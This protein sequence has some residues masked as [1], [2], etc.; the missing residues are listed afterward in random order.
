MLSGGSLSLTGL[1]VRNG[2]ASSGSNEQHGG[3]IRNAATLSIDSSVITGNT[4]QNASG[5]GVYST[6]TLIVTSSTISNNRTTGAGANGAGIFSGQAASSLS[7]AD[8]TIAH[9]TADGD[10]G[11][12]T[13]EQGWASIVRSAVTENTTRFTGLGGGIVALTGTLVVVDSNIS[14]N[15][16]ATIG[17]GIFAGGTFSLTRSSI[18]NN[19]A[20]TDGGGVRTG[21]TGGDAEITSSTISGNRSVGFG[22]G[23]EHAASSRNDILR[24]TNSTISD[25]RVWRDNQPAYG[26]GG[27]IALFGESTTI[28]TLRLFHVTLAGNDGQGGGSAIYAV[29]GR[30][31]V[32]NSILDGGAACQANGSVF[33]SLGNN[34]ERGNT[35]GFGAPSDRTNVDPLLGALANNGGATNTN[36]PLAGSP[37]IDGVVGVCA[38]ATDQ[39]GQPRPRDGDGNGTAICDIGA[40]ELQ[41]PYPSISSF[42]INAGQMATNA[43]TVTL[44]LAASASAAEMRFS[45]DGTNWPVGWV[46]F[47][48]SAPWTVPSG[49]GTKTVYA[50]V[51]DSSGNASAI[52]TDTIVLDTTANAGSLSVNADAPATNTLNVTLSL[53]AVDPDTGITELSFSNTNN[54]TDWTGWEPFATSKSWTLA[55]GSD[56]T[57]TVFARVRDGVGNVSPAFS[58]TILYD[59]TAPTIST[60]V[61]NDGALATTS[62]SVNLKLQASD[63]GGGSGVSEM[64]FSNDNGATWLAWETYA[65]TKPWTL[66]TG[67]GPKTV[68]VR[69]RD[70]A[71]NVSAPVSD[72]ITLDTAVGTS[73]GISINSAAVWTNTTAVTLSIPAAPGTA[74]MM[75]SNDGGFP[76]AQWQPYD[77][78]YSPWTLDRF[79]GSPVTMIVYV[80]FGDA[81][82]NELPNS[83]S[84]DNIVLDIDPPTGSVAVVGGPSPGGAGAPTPNSPVRT[85]QLTAT[86]TQSGSAMQM[87]LSNRADFAGAIWK[88]FASPVSWD[89]TGGNTV[90]AQFKDGAGNVSQV[91]S[92]TIAGGVGPGSSPSPSCLPRPRVIVNVLK[93]G[94]QLLVTLATTGANNGLKAVR[95]DSFANAVVD[96]GSQTN[97]SAPFAVSIPA[98]Q[99]PTSLQF[100]VRRQ[101]GAQSATV[102]LVVIDGCGEWSTFVG[103]GPGAEHA[104]VG[105][106][107]M[108]GRHAR[109]LPDRVLEPHLGA[110]GP[111]RRLAVG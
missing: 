52:R 105:E 54:G 41:N 9:N 60:F 92:Q 109:H 7:V 35:C 57:R 85:V 51:R 107:E 72:I 87:R 71:G 95:F 75:L 19:E 11:G 78:H 73:F 38:Q 94:A 47:A 90:Y 70:A 64:A 88:P 59:T 91:Y 43:M 5:G 49:D 46:T 103:G 53:N 31:S 14:S 8:S 97:Q 48:T 44:T 86:D 28:A 12:I 104:A 36:A 106:A 16:A 55:A 27:G 33:E 67:D 23:I 20:H 68:Q 15:T 63:T 56:G 83:R 39:R 58:D 50:Q 110:G 1:T 30:V 42:A 13:L 24:I 37:A 99:E 93:S 84:S 98:G 40:Y 62:I 74:K 100:T 96:V 102:R 18:T 77:S 65:T 2:R 79:E 34:V 4:A 32:H 21:G 61:V 25:N 29:S 6:G 108:R 82:G 3:G 69:V 76:G 101:P 80:R 17:G 26:N 89:F 45:N 22:G 10:G 66:A 111:R 81:N